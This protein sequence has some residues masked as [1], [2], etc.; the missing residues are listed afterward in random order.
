MNKISL[1]LVVLLAG[2]PNTATRSGDNIGIISSDNNPNTMI[3][4]VGKIVNK[5]GII[6]IK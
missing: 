5:T 2:C 3:K 6:N 4:I 1:S